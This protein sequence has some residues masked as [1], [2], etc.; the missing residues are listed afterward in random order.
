MPLQKQSTWVGNPHGAELSIQS[1][2]VRVAA[3]NAQV[4]LITLIKG[5]FNS[6]APVDVPLCGEHSLTG[7]GLEG[8]VIEVSHQC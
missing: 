8:D 5:A 2:L 4:Q 1:A 7:G 3:G 6:G